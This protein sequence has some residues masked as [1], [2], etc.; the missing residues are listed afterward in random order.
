MNLS[1]PFP[2]VTIAA[3]SHHSPTFASTPLQLGVSKAI[4]IHTS[5]VCYFIKFFK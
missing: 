1:V 4:G 5:R 3:V 2:G